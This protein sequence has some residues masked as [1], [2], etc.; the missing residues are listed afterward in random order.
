MEIPQGR[1]RV[2]GSAWSSPDQIQADKEK[3]EQEDQAKAT[4]FE[5][6]KSK[7]NVLTIFRQ[8]PFS[9]ATHKKAF[10]YIELYKD[11]VEKAIIYFFKQATCAQFCDLVRRQIFDGLFQS[12]DLE[13]FLAD[14]EGNFDDTNEPPPSNE[15]L[16][17][18]IN[19]GLDSF[20]FKITNSWQ[21]SATQKANLIKAIN[22]HK[23]TLSVHQ[24]QGGDDSDDSDDD[25]EDDTLR[26]LTE[27]PVKGNSSNCCTIL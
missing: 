10:V 16:A 11:K 12:Y 25:A 19:I 17:K 24:E 27:I 20:Y 13:L 23:Q 15:V 8:T 18:I 1:G 2:K 7:D 26:K 21:L 3:K 5:E 9:E 14:D 22:D 4:P 6:F